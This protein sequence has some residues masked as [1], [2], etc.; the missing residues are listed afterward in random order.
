MSRSYWTICAGVYYITK[1]NNADVSVHC[2]RY[3]VYTYI[4]G[5]TNLS[6][7]YTRACSPLRALLQRSY[8]R[9]LFEQETYSQSAIEEEL[10]PLLE[11]D[12]HIGRKSTEES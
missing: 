8:P 9:F 10:Q 6:R 11:W 4:S 12:F 3:T 2:V 5:K 1:C 7:I